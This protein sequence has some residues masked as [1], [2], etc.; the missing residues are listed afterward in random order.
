LEI[1]IVID[2][3]IWQGHMRETKIVVV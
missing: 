1:I 2:I 3:Y